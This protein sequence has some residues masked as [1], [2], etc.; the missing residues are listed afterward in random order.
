MKATVRSFCRLYVPA[1]K[2]ILWYTREKEEGAEAQLASE[3]AAIK[4][5]E[6]DLMAEVRRVFLFISG[7]VGLKHD[8]WR[9]QRTLRMHLAAKTSRLAAGGHHEA[10]GGPHG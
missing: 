4:E 3:L 1:G 9:T 2:D 7:G 10:Q 5:R 8:Y 6:E